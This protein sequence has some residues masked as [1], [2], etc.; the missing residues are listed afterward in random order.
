M[1]FPFTTANL[2][3]HHHRRLQESGPGLECLPCE[4]GAGLNFMWLKVT[5]V[6]KAFFWALSL[7]FA[8]SLKHWCGK[9]V[10]VSCVGKTWK[11]CGQNIFCQTSFFYTCSSSSTIYSSISKSETD[12]ASKSFHLLFKS[13]GRQKHIFSDL[14][15]L[16][17]LWLVAYYIGMPLAEYHI[18]ELCWGKILFSFVVGVFLVFPVAME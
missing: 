14:V 1:S 12:L 10:L 17:L 5:W 11:T 6:A 7:H 18:V 13:N 4:Q 2:L 9:G 8:L 16:N 3:P 15:F